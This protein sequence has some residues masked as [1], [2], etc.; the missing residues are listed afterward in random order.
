MIEPKYPT[1]KPDRDRYRRWYLDEDVKVTLHNGHTYTIGKGFRFDAHSVPFIFRIFF[2]QTDFD[3]YA[4]L[5]H[6]WLVDTAPWHR[7]NRK[8]I[9]TEY[10]IMMN[11]KTYKVSN[12]RSYF[13][14]LAVRV[15][16][17]LMFD[18]W[19]DKRGEPTQAN[20]IIM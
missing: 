12:L 11:D 17:W 15:Y 16:G 13:M 9:D 5:V 19:G 7:Y 20:G 14:P 4:S 10:K 1:I 18:L 2:R 6:D 3:V 8:F